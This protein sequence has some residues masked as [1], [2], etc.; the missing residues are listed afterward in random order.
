MC[1]C[2]FY[3]WK[4]KIGYMMEEV[5]KEGWRQKVVECIWNESSKKDYLRREKR[6]EKGERGQER[7]M[8]DGQL[9]MSYNDTHMHSN[10]SETHHLVYAKNKFYLH[11]T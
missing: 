7:A 8:Y 11:Y 6:P 2:V 9:R 1:M 10:V 3:T 4:Y 5:W